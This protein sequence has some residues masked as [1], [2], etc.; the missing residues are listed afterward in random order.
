ME[1]S[2]FMPLETIME[3]DKYENNYSSPPRTPSFDHGQHNF[4]MIETP[5]RSTCSIDTDNA[6]VSGFKLPNFAGSRLVNMILGSNRELSHSVDSV[7]NNHSNSFSTPFVL[8]SP[9]PRRH[10]CIEPS[11]LAMSDGRA[12][13]D[14]PL[15]PPFQEEKIPGENSVLLNLE[16]QIAYQDKPLEYCTIKIPDLSVVEEESLDSSRSKSPVID[17]ANITLPLD[18]SSSSDEANT[19]C[20]SLTT[21]SDSQSTSSYSG[22]LK[23]Q[24]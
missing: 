1:E 16:D 4:S 18:A 6:S 13:P 19:S 12:T 9:C 3:D 22:L 11:P 14:Q 24:I 10:S 7:K 15:L 17:P 2:E 20:E 23:N 21:S 5:T 8:R